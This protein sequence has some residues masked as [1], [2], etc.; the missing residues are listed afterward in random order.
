MRKFFTLILGLVFV[1]AVTAQ[2]PEG[3]IIKASVAP[4]I[5]GVID[6]VWE[7]ANV[8]NIDKKFAAELPTLG[9]PGETTWKALW[10]EDGYYLLLQVTDDSYW[11]SWIAGGDSYKRDKPEVYFDVNYVLV[12]GLGCQGNINK[13]HYQFD[14]AM[15]KDHVAGEVGNI[16]EQRSNLPFTYT[17][18][19]M[20]DEPNYLAEYFFPFSM[21]VTKDNSPMDL[22]GQVGFDVTI[23]D[24]DEGDPLDPRKR[25]VWA[26]VG[27]V[28]ESWANM[29]DAGI[30][31]FDGAEPPVLIEA[32]NLSVDGAITADN[33]TLQVMAEI[34]PD[35]A[36]KTIKWTIK[37]ADGSAARASISSEGVIIPMLDEEVIVS[38]ASL[39]GFILSDP[40]TV[41]I[42]GQKVTLDEINY[43]K[44]G[45]FKVF[46]AE[47]G[48]VGAPWTGGGVVADGVCS[49]NNAEKDVDP[50][51]WIM[52]QVV[53]TPYDKR[54]DTYEY[55]FKMWADAAREVVIDFEDPN[56]GYQRY[57]VSADLTATREGGG[58][59]DW[60]MPITTEPTWYTLTTTFANMQ[61]GAKQQ[62]NLMMGWDTPIVYIDSVYLVNVNDKALVSTSISQVRSME[63]LNVYPNPAVDK[64][65]VDLSTANTIVTIYNN[66]GVK[67]DEA[68][69][70]GTHHM[71]D[72]SRYAKGLYFV[73]ANGAVIK[74]IK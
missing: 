41:S 69:V 64:L 38:A 9:D 59:S 68:V 29:D 17:Y 47:T 27:A 53:F 33:Q 37:K 26:N 46:N 18:A 74:F 71:F 13:G 55:S 62:M 24:S 15:D 49:M 31:T 52:G 72:V 34:L 56:H 22:T 19:F 32:I 50:W 65:H 40:V 5:D 61:E 14:V 28:T 42:S 21:F 57:G 60:L 20:V 58:K 23:C 4:A 45:D 39:D 70:S 67:M 25:A 2:K 51:G 43:I 10:T 73:K 35:D 16:N 48:A 3:I 36:P 30:I 44:N 1:S 63:T 6:D 54:A 11:P 8:Y 66:V 7:E 12:D